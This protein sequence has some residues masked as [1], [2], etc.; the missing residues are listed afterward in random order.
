[1]D[2]LGE[3]ECEGC[4]MQPVDMTLWQEAQEHIALHWHTKLYDKKV[5]LTANG[6]EL[7]KFPHPDSKLSIRCRYGVITSQLHRY[8]V[9][10]PADAALPSSSPAA[11]S[12]TPS[13]STPTCLLAV[14]SPSVTSSLK[15]F[16][17]YSAS[18]T[19]TIYPTL[20]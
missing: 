12:Q 8:N 2:K 6:L 7:N 1:M 15:L 5:K 4:S 11:S 13:G 20:P 19:T 16:S 17:L 18:S 3:P 9:P 14:L 10:V